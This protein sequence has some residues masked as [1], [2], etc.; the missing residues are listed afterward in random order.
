MYMCCIAKFRIYNPT[1]KE[2]QA[3]RKREKLYK[4]FLFEYVIILNH[5]ALLIVNQYLALIS[6]TNISLF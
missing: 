4:I 6:V 2:E 1:N 3:T 5:V